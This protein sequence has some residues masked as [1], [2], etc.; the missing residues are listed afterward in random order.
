MHGILLNS[1]SNSL[2]FD[3]VRF[4]IEV[5]VDV[6]CMYKNVTLNTR[7]LPAIAAALLSPYSMTEISAHSGV[8]ILGLC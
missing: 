3:I 2:S 5:G 1:V 8:N 4:K 7:E 6:K